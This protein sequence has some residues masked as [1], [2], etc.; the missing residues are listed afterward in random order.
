MTR[1]DRPVLGQRT[2]RG[3]GLGRQATLMPKSSLLI[4]GPTQVGKTSSLVM[5]ALLRWN[6]ALVVTSVKRDVIKSTQ[7][8]RQSLGEVQ[9]LEPGR[10]SGL[11]WNP[12]EGV[13]SLRHALR[14][15]RDLTIGSRG[16]GDTDFWNALAT[17]LVAALF[18]MA[19][20]RSQSIFD[21]AALVENRKFDQWMSHVVTNEASELLRTFLEHEHKTLDGVLTTA[22]TMLLPWR[23]RQPLA[24]VRSVVAGANTLYLCSPRGEQQ[25]YESL[26]RGALRMVL[27]EQH[28]LVDEGSQRRLLLVLDEAATVA[29]LDELDQLAATVSG[30]DVTLVTVV[31]DFAQLVARWGARAPTI[32]NNHT[33]RIVMGGLS[34]PSV[35]KYFPEMVV[36]KDDTRTMPLRQRSPGTALVVSGRRPLFEVHVRP[37]WRSRRLRKRGER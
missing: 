22:E 29:P 10:D 37:W 33:T 11:T 20:Q 21:V 31:Q 5:P 30:L 9:I 28:R 1:N 14:V 18:V 12:L 35:G 32:V 2:Y 23:F 25:H 8:W 15:A 4:V 7:R 36:A 27:E 26:F 24:N 17:K 34:D 19:D 16:Q 3:I 6:D 13:T